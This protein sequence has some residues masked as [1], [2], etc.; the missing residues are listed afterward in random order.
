[1]FSHLTWKKDFFSRK[2]WGG[3]GGGELAPPTPNPPPPAPFLY[4]L[5]KRDLLFKI[6]AAV[7]KFFQFSKL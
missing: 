3:G 1:M 7:Q 6:K 2:D 5:I 4:S